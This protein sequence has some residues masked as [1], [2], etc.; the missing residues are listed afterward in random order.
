M[1]RAAAGGLQLSLGRN[2]F[3]STGA[4]SPGTPQA[5]KV[6]D[7]VVMEITRVVVDLDRVPMYYEGLP[8]VLFLASTTM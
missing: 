5:V 7:K 8:P 1:V 2:S 6:S 4:S 3:G